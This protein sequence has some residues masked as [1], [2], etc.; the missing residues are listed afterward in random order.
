MLSGHNQ[1]SMVVLLPQCLILVVWSQRRATPCNLSILLRPEDSQQSLNW[2]PFMGN[3]EYKKCPKIFWNSWQMHM[4]KL[5]EQLGI[6]PSTKQP[7]A[8]AR[9]AAFELI[10]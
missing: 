7:S 1:K 2:W 5:H 10:L 9:I 8:E 4:R 6:N 3:I